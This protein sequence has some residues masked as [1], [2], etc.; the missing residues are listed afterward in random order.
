MNEDRSHFRITGLPAERFRHLFDLSD[1]EL[2]AHHARRY[3]VDAK[4]GFPDRIEMR[5]AEVG[6]SVILVNHTHL[7]DASPYRAS[8]AVFVIEG[9]TATYDAVD[10]IP[11][12]LRTRM[13]SL[14]G[15]DRDGMMVD[16][17]LVDGQAVESLI[18]RLFANPAIAFIHA[19]YARR[20]CYACRIDRVVAGE[21]H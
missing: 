7:P 17:D 5:D 6:E 11:A 20:G 19:H 14:R 2:V 12:P 9:A 1:E 3:V 21:V 8:H 4:P 13:L 18:E 16:A 15:F 10:Q